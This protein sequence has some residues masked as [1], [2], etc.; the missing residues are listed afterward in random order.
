ML[1]Q[2]QNQE[3]EQLL[4][5]KNSEVEKLRKNKDSQISILKTKKSNLQDLFDLQN[6]K[7][8]ARKDELAQTKVSCEK[9][10]ESCKGFKMF[11]G[12]EVHT[13]KITPPRVYQ[14]RQFPTFVYIPQI[15]T[16]K[17]RKT[18]LESDHNNNFSE[19]TEIAP[20]MS[21][22]QSS[23]GTTLLETSDNPVT[24]LD[25]GKR[26]MVDIKFPP[27]HPHPPYPIM[28]ANKPFIPNYSS[29][30]PTCLKCFKYNHSTENCRTKTP[31]E[32]A[33]DRLKAE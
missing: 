6:E 25:K 30:S 5:N 10:V 16:W 12:K 21:S 8:S 13:I 22:T 9:W 17:N 23:E 28:K 14:P 29:L 32:K 15:L 4:A 3:L 1:L 2:Q 18:R 19:Q 31:L 27:S 26:L 33:R 20:A 7:S 11:L 24:Y